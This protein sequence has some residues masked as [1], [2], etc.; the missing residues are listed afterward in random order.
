MFVYGMIGGVLSTIITILY[1][2]IT[3]AWLKM[4]FYLLPPGAG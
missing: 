4:D 3:V 1:F 2:V